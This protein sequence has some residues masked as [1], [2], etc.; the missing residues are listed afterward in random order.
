MSSPIVLHL[1]TVSFSKNCK[2]PP[3]TKGED[4]PESNRLSIKISPVIVDFGRLLQGQSKLAEEVI[5]GI[6]NTDL[7][8]AAAN[9]YGVSLSEVTDDI[10]YPT[11]L[12]KWSK[13]L[14]MIRD[15]D[16]SVE[17]MKRNLKLRKEN[18]SANDSSFVSSSE[19]RRTLQERNNDM[20]KVEADER[21]V[22]IFSDSDT[23]DDDEEVEDDNFM[24][25]VEKFFQN[26]DERKQVRE[27]WMQSDQ[28]DSF[29]T[30]GIENR[31]VGCMSFERSYEK[32]GQRVL[33]LTLIAV[34]R[35]YR[36]RGIGQFMMKQIFD[37]TITGGSD[38]IVVN[39][40]NSAVNFFEREGF[41]DD[42]LLNSQ[43]AHIG[44]VWFNCRRMCHLPSYFS[45]KIQRPVKS[46]NEEPLA[47]ELDLRELELELSLWK[48]RSLQAY[49]SH[50]GL[51]QRMRREIL[52]LRARVSVQEDMIVNLR[53]ELDASKESRLETEQEHLRNRLTN[54]KDAMNIL[55]ENVSVVDEDEEIPIEVGESSS[56]AQD[57]TS[58]SSTQQGVAFFTQSSTQFNPG[59][60]A[61]EKTNT[62]RGV[63]SE[64]MAS[65]GSSTDQDPP[66]ISSLNDL[67][68][69]SCV[70][71][72]DT[73][74]SLHQKKRNSEKKSSA[75]TPFKDLLS[76]DFALL[77]IKQC[78]ISS[79]ESGDNNFSGTSYDIINVTDIIPA[80]LPLGITARFNSCVSSSHDPDIVANLYYCGS[81]TST[82]SERM[83]HILYHGFSVVDFAQSDY[84]KG[85]HF[86][87]H[88]RSAA[89][90]S[91][92]GQI[93]VA[94][95]CLGQTQTIT[96]KNNQ[97]KSPPDGFDSILT[98][99]RLSEASDIS[100]S[101]SVGHSEY[102]I[103]RHDQALPLALIEYNLIC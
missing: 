28:K 19:T 31:L 72:S 83:K 97:R 40:D 102:V 4:A 100:R 62:S 98:Q 30:L 38:A 26:V 11:L 16:E 18:L 95:V 1:P 79:M 92:S 53:A 42:V 21:F 43:Y 76:S 87:R 7:L 74:R 59:L 73:S 44:D 24:S 2:V 47:P 45:G 77:E 52:M 63:T 71:S 94:K 37:Q 86:S 32:P 80:E 5:P 57:V 14:L 58:T 51:I 36:G 68:T 34:R 9:L 17:K 48:E 81:Q 96:S 64:V 15:Q 69:N 93:L 3:K 65:H 27:R 82:N 101:W 12:E 22:S 41:T 75:L 25:G 55:E 50:A 35:K 8:H 78:F 23:S 39:A 20:K 46:D 70:S 103:F 49:Q 13:T 56:S 29:P 85:L 66:S 91:P 84:G 33:Q 61:N 88:A 10:I 90:F 60:I 54:L 99:G 67:E 6:P 89:R